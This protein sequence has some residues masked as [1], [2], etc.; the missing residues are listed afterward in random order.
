M[1]GVGSWELGVGRLERKEHIE[2]ELFL[3]FWA[4]KCYLA[5]TWA[6]RAESFNH[7]NNGLNHT[8]TKL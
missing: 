8:K 6:V 4:R 3:S 1:Q 7:V 5:G 2:L